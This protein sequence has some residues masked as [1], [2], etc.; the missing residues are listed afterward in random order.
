MFT[1]DDWQEVGKTKGDSPVYR[2]KVVCGW[3]VHLGGGV[4]FY[5][6]SEH[7]W[8]SNSLPEIYS[9]LACCVFK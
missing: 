5:P 9:P 8:D 1:R 2:L 7:K 3:L 6:D 4:T